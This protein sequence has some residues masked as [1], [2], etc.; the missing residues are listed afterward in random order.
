MG[1]L[2]LFLRIA[3]S[4]L[5]VTMGLVFLPTAPSCLLVQRFIRT[6]LFW[7]GFWLV[8]FLSR[9]IF[10]GKI[11][12]K[13]ILRCWCFLERIVLRG[14]LLLCAD[15]LAF[16]V[17][18]ASLIGQFELLECVWCIIWLLFFTCFFLGTSIEWHDVFC[19]AA[20]IKI[21]IIS[22]LI[23]VLIFFLFAS[24]HFVLGVEC[25][26]AVII[27]NKGAIGAVWWCFLFDFVLLCL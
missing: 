24:F 23:L 10:T 22:T 6:Y 19:I 25:I 21:S 7:F 2:L 8:Q 27:L 12:W 26:D 1:L 15:K 3:F 16:C 13:T 9:A 20:V 4:L 5:I 14:W 18:E 11:E 17:N